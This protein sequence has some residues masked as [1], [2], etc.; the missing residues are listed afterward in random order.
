MGIGFIFPTLMAVGIMFMDESPRW[1]YRKGNIERARKTLSHSYGVSENH[2]E[3]RREMFEIK[4]KFEAE[5]QAVWHEFVTGP[6]MTYRLLLGIVLQALQ[7]LTG[8]KFRIL[9]ARFQS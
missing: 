2:R 9:L 6:K 3:V 1:D 5:K 7:Q 8:G 4:E